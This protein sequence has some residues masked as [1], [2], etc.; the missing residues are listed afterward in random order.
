MFWVLSA[1]PCNKLLNA[2]LYVWEMCA[3]K[4]WSYLT[5]Q[6]ISSQAEKYFLSSFW[7]Y[8]AVLH[9]PEL[10]LATDS[11]TYTYIRT[12]VRSDLRT[13][14]TSYPW[15]RST[16]VTHCLDRSERPTQDWSEEKILTWHNSKCA[17]VHMHT[18]YWWCEHDGCVEWRY[19]V[20]LLKPTNHLLLRSCQAGETQVSALHMWMLLTQA[21][22]IPT[23]V[24]I[25]QVQPRWQ[26]DFWHQ[27]DLVWVIGPP[28]AL[29]HLAGN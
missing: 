17:R 7:F 14:W 13:T 5:A 18:E 1:S 29:V 19:M 23:T 11:H 16:D 2:H 22:S 26:G 28:R 9:I 24:N 21:R 4:S 8:W 10:S 15:A 25:A 20:H 27:P 12:H 3:F 6:T